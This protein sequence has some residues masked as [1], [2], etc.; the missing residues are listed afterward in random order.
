MGQDFI[1]KCHNCGKTFPIS[2]GG[3]FFFHLLHCNRCGRSKSISFKK[4]GELHLRYLKG[5]TIPYCSASS[6]H[7]RYVR[8]NIQIEPISEMEY[9]KQV[10]KICGRCWWCFGLGKFKI[11]APPR[12]PKCRSSNF[13]KIASG[14]LYD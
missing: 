6:E 8:E 9:Y 10:E 5:L 13:E 11:K 12:C 7:D 2:I 4:L 14:M 3:G 1:A